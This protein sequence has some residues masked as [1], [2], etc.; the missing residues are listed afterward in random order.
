MIQAQIDKRYVAI[1]LLEAICKDND[2][3]EETLRSVLKDKE[4]YLEKR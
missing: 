2:M 1:L 4:K 3:P